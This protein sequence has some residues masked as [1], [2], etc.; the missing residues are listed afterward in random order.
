MGDD[1]KPIANP[2]VVLREEFDDW[3]V[4]FNPDADLG[5]AGFGLNPTGVHLWKLL[6]GEH[7]LD[8]LVDEIARFSESVPEESRDHIRAFVDTLALKGLA[9]YGNARFYAERDSRLPV[10]LLSEAKSCSY[11]PPRLID[12]GSEVVARGA[13]GS[14]GSQ[15]GV[16]CAS[17]TA[18]A[19]CCGS[20]SC[21][22]AYGAP[23]CSGTC[24]T[25]TCQS[26]SGACDA[27][28]QTGTSNAGNCGLGSSPSYSC[29]D[30]G[31]PGNGQCRCGSG[32]G[33]SLGG[34]IC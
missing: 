1:E 33:C 7:A 18:A 14:H 23:C 21:G 28:C 24:G 30:G 16:S 34:A 20:G 31:S 32:G 22:A 19:A 26:G 10:Q 8:D 12:L 15:I 25:A 27:W 4:L 9:A 3:A 29:I 13:C 2:H 5:Y 6:D 17:G 11:E